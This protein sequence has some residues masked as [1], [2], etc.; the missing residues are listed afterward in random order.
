M[1]ITKEHKRIAKKKGWYEGHAK[2][3]KESWPYDE[4]QLCIEYEQGYYEGLDADVN[5]K[6]PYGVY[7]PSA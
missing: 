6:K 4:I 2:R 3:D 5:A 1:R 7:L